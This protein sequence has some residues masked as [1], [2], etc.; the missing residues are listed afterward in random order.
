MMFGISSAPEQNK[1]THHWVSVRTRPCSGQK[2]GRKRNIFMETS[3][4]RGKR[5]NFR[6][7][8]ASDLAERISA[9]PA[10]FSLE[11]LNGK[12]QLHY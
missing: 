7:P 12:R 3:K 10:H 5:D 4:G 8:L 6:R 9:L 2:N 11:I 1:L